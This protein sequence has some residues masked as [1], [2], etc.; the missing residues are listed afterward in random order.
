VKWEYMVWTI[1]HG[2]ILTV[3]NK[4]VGRVVTGFMGV[5]ADGPVFTEYLNQAGDQ[6]WEV[7]GISPTHQEPDVTDI[8]SLV[9]LKR[10]KA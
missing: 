6:G 3:D 1:C 5:Q 4:T 9:V 10:P 7:V 8:Q 2:V